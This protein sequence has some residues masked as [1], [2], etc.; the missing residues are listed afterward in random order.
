[1]RSSRSPGR[2]FGNARLERVDD[3]QGSPVSPRGAL[4]SCASQDFTNCTRWDWLWVHSN[5]AGDIRD[6]DK[7]LHVDIGSRPSQGL[8]WLYIGLCFL[9]AGSFL[10]LMDLATNLDQLTAKVPKLTVE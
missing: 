8:Y 2:S 3:Q 6:Q 4:R 9:Q 1:M 7:R 5:S 10:T